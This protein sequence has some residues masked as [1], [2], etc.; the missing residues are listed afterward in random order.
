MTLSVTLIGGPTALLEIDGFRLL[1]DPTFDAPGAYQLP[2]V[3][4][5]AS[6]LNGVASRQRAS[7]PL[8]PLLPPLRA[9]AAGHSRSA[10]D[11]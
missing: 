1:T 9:F 11:C 6:P 7:V 3:T 5:G 4:L 8:K 2:H 10:R